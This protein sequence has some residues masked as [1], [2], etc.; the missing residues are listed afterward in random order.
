MALNYSK[1]VITHKKQRKTMEIKTQE[2]HQYKF[3]LT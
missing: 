1:L 3:R 2:Y